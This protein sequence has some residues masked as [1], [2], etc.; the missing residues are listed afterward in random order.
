MSEWRDARPD[1]SGKYA[2]IERLPIDA[3][4]TL[5]TMYSANDKVSW[6]YWTPS[7]WAPLHSRVCVCERP[8]DEAVPQFLG[9]C[10]DCVRVE[11]KHEPT[12]VMFRAGLLAARELIANE[13]VR[14]GLNASSY[15]VRFLWWPSLGVDP[16]RETADDACAEALPIAMAFAEKNGA[17]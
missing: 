17:K 8:G 7:G 4:P 11:L 13:C 6:S 10:K 16:T 14:R 3:P 1:D 15:I 9:E 5:L 2:Y 12:D